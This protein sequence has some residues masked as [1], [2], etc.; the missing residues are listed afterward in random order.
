MLIALAVNQCVSSLFVHRD[1]RWLAFRIQE[2]SISPV[3]LGKVYPGEMDK[4]FAFVSYAEEEKTW[5]NHWYG[6]SLCMTGWR[7]LHH[8]IRS[9]MT[10]GLKVKE[11]GGF[12]YLFGFYSQISLVDTEVW[13]CSTVQGV[14]CL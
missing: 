4:G 13:A 12:I 11:R 5:V 3:Y 1:L 14:I 10:S 9:V 8:T 7:T 2:I 6:S